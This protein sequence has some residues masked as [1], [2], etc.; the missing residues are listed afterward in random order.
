MMNGVSKYPKKLIKE[1]AEEID[2]GMICFLNTDTLEMD[3]VLGQSYTIYG[4]DDYSQEVYDKVDS[5]E[6]V[7]RF[8]PLLSW[9]SFK[10]M[11]DF[12]ESC[13]PDKDIVKSRLWNALSR[14]KPFQNFKI[15][16]D[17]SPYRQCWFD[18]KQSRLEQFVAE[19]LDS[20][21]EA[22]S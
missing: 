9:Q 12:T 11:E 22:E 19:Q 13:I 1:I 8:E 15:I 14:R 10:I 4:D 21:E 2:V 7:I 18:F 20:S 16:I 17:N 6:N 5:W 3:S